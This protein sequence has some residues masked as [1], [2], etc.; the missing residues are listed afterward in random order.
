MCVSTL[1]VR[2]CIRK[3]SDMKLIIKGL[4]IIFQRLKIFVR[5]VIDVQ[6]YIKTR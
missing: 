2:N 3:R 4:L 6:A 1:T 5:I